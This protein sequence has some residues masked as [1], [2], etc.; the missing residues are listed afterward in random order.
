MS[1]TTYFPAANMQRRLHEGPLGIHI[2]LY[3]GQLESEGH[4][5][6]SAWRCLRVVSD[7]SHWLD[8]KGIGVTE[9]NEQVVQN[10]Q[11]FRARYRC[12]FLSD[13]PALMRLLAVLRNVNAIPAK[14]LLALSACDQ[15]VADFRHHLVRVRGLAH[16][17][18]IRGEPVVRQFLKEVCR[19]RPSHVA[20]VTRPDILAFVERH[21]RDHS[22]RSAQLMCSA[23]RSFLR[24]LHYSGII[25]DDLT[26]AIPSIRRWRLTSLPTYLSSAQVEEVLQTFNRR[27][28]TGRRDYAIL[29]DID[30]EAGALTILAKGRKRTQVP[31]LPAVGDAIADYLQ[32]G[33]SQCDC[34]RLFLRSTAPHIGFASSSAIS[35]I[36]NAALKRANIDGVAHKGAHLFRHSLATELLRARASLTEIGQVLHHQNPNTTAIY[37]KVD[38]QNLRTVALPWPAGVR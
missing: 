25:D 9:I 31:L 27:T 36:A 16:V 3:A 35:M 33:R 14:P 26:S 17:S 12:P 37:A 23:L 2:D 38:L 11:R 21:I 32:D 6:Q 8:R 30:W 22:P 24:Y 10:Y 7:F 1:T 34:R 19:S 5:L 29:V 28:P 13:Q 20:K 18:I 4:C 15:I